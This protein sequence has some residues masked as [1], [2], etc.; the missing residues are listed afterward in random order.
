MFLDMKNLP[1]I[2]NLP[3]PELK[4]VEKA[5][6]KMLQ[7]DAESEALKLKLWSLEVSTAFNDY[8]KT[9][10]HNLKW[11]VVGDW[12][13]TNESSLTPTER[14]R[15]I[16]GL[17]LDYPY[18]LIIVKPNSRGL[19]KDKCYEDVF[20]VPCVNIYYTYLGLSQIEN[21]RSVMDAIVYFFTSR[22]G[23]GADDYI[24]G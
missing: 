12:V 10:S 13:L 6:Q 1:S 23:I 3:L 20:I 18:E 15:L 19:Y 11:M 22:F 17:S 5:R 9:L 24:A 8:Y 4:N 21:P 2:S 7:Q 14:T 16:G